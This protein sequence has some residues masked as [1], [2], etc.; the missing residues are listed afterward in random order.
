MEEDRHREKSC[1]VRE[2]RADG[3]GIPA[4]VRVVDRH[5]RGARSRR[6]RC[7]LAEARRLD[8]GRVRE[9]HADFRRSGGLRERTD[10]HVDLGGEG[11]GLAVRR[12]RHQ[13]IEA[14]DP[15]ARRLDVGA[16]SLAVRVDER[17]GADREAF[18][19]QQTSD[20][21][22]HAGRAGAATFRFA[23]TARREHRERCA[24]PASPRSE[25]PACRVPRAASS[26][27]ARSWR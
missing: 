18:G 17:R 7:D 14:I 26:R 4:A 19:A 1:Q 15:G 11:E 20:R 24:R 25:H 8:L 27:G 10:E 22:A 12:Q 13:Q 3:E 2:Q 6:G 16:R 5:A 9:S 21:Q 23:N